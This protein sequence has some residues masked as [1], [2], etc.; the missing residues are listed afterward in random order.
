MKNYMRKMV[1]AICLLVAMAA[2]AE[3]QNSFA[4]QAVIRTAKGELVSNQEVGMRISLIYNDQTIYSETHTPK[5]NQYGNVQVKVGEGTVE[6]GSFAAVPWSTMQVMMKIEADPNGGT[7]Y[8]DLGSIQLQ[9]A[10]YAMYAPTAGAV[11]TVQAGDPKSDSAALF[12][13]KDKDGNVV[14]AVYP[15]GVRVFV[16]D[17]DS[18]KAARTGFAVQGRRAAKDGEEANYFEV[19][20]DGTQV[21][22]EETDTAA[23][24][25]A[26]T[27]FAVSGRR[28]A[29]DV[30][31]DLFTVGSTGTQ[32]Y[33]DEDAAKATRTGFAVQGRRAAKDGDSD[34]YLEI[35]PDGTRVYI[36]NE[37][38]STKAVR[39]GF[40]VQGRRAAKDDADSKIFEINADGTRVYVD[41]EKAVRTGF[42]VQGRRAAKGSTPK[43]FEVNSYGTQI[44]I[45]TEGKPMSTGL[46]VSGRRASKN[47]SQNV[48]YM[49]ID[50]DGT[51][52]YVDYDEA[53]A[54]RTGFA[55]SGR[56]AAKD[57]EQNT[58]LE[59]NNQEG[60][61]AYV[62]VIE[63]KAMPTGFAVSGRKAAKDGEP[64][65]L[66]ITSEKSTLTATNFAMQDKQT[67]NN[68]MSITPETTKLTTD[69]LRLLSHDDSEVLS[70]TSGNVDVK[71]ELVVT[72]EVA[73]TVEVKKIDIHP[74]YL[75]VGEKID[76]VLCADT[77]SVLDASN[78]YVLLKIYG[79]GLFAPSKTVDVEGNSVILF[80]GNGNPT[81]Q[82]DV[83]AAAVIMTKASTPDAK[84][85]IW[86]LKQ[87]NAR[88]IRFG[89]MAAGDTTKQY[90]PVEAFLNS[91][92]P[93]ECLV[94]VKSAV[95]SL[96]TV[97]VVG[98]KV[99]GEKVKLTPQ[100]IEGY[101]FTGWS[102]GRTINPRTVLILHDTAFASAN[103]EINTYNIK[104]IAENGTVEIS[105]EQNEDG[106]YNHGTDIALTAFAAEHY[107]FMGWTDG[108]TA[109]V[110]KFK[111]VSDTTFE[112]AFA[113]DSFSISTLAEN[114]TVTGAGRYPYGTEI[115][116]VAIADTLAGYHFANWSDGDN[117]NPRKIK[118][119][120]NM[121]LTAQFAI[122]H[123]TI[124]YK[125]DDEV[126]GEIE[127]VAY[128]EP[129]A[130]REE[131][132]KEGYTFSGWSQI[133]ATMPMGNV[134]VTGSF[135]IN[136]HTITYMVDGDVYKKFENIPYAS[137]LSVIDNPE[138]KEGYTFS[139]WSELPVTMPDEDVVVTGSF[140]INEYEIA[141]VDYDGK[142]LQSGNVAYGQ[143]PVYETDEPAHA[144][145]AQYTF[146][147]NGW[148][149]ETKPVNG[150]LTYTA[151]YD[152]TVN[153]YAV[154][155]VAENGSVK[156]TTANGNEIEN[157]KK[158]D[159]NTEVTLTATSSVSGYYFIRWSD[160]VTDNPR[161]FNIVKDTAFTAVYK[162]DFIAD[163]LKYI[164]TSASTVSVGKID[165]DNKPTGELTI[166]ATVKD[167]DG[168]QYYVTKVKSYAFD[169]CKDL[170]EVIISE[171][172]MRIDYNAFYDCSSLTSVTIPNSVTS[173]GQEAFYNCS[174]L[175]SVTIPNT[176][177]NIG[178]NAFYNCSMTSVTIPTSV[179][180]IGGDE[181]QFVGGGPFA[182]CDKLE[183]INVDAENA[184]YISLDGVLYSKD[185]TLLVQY[186][187]G[188]QDTLY[189]VH[190]SVKTI[191]FMAFNACKNLKYVAIP[192][193]VK[194]LARY[195]FHFCGHSQKVT[196]P[197]SCTDVKTAAYSKAN[198]PTVY[199]RVSEE[200]APKVV[201]DGNAVFNCK[202]IKLV[203]A[204][205][206]L[207]TATFATP[208]GMGA[209][210]ST[211]F[212]AGTEIELIAN[213]VLGYELES[214]K[215]GE[216][217]IEPTTDGLYK[218]TVTTD[219]TITATW[220]QKHTVTFY[221][222]KEGGSTPVNQLFGSVTP[223]KLPTASSLSFSA[224]EG[225]N[226]AGW[227]TS[228]DGVPVYTD[229]QEITLDNDISL[230]AVWAK[231]TGI[232]CPQQP[233]EQG[234]TLMLKSG[235]TRYGVGEL[236][237]SS[238][239]WNMTLEQGETPVKTFS[240]LKIP[241]DTE[242]TNGA[243]YMLHAVMAYGQITETADFML[244]GGHPEAP[245]GFVYVSGATVSG[246]VSGSSVFIEGRTLDIQYMFVSDH[247]VT[248]AEFEAVMGTNPS[249]FSSATADGE[250]QANRPVEYVN[251][252]AAIAYCNKKSL[253]DGLTPCYTVSAVTDWANL[254][255]SSIPTSSNGT[256][257]AATC[258]FNANGYRL[259]TEAEWEFLARGGN[260][261][262]EGQTDYSGSN[263]IDNV[264]WYSG[265]SDSKTHEVNKKT[266]NSLGI[267]DMSGNV[268]EWCWD[269]TE[270][271]NGGN[272]ITAITAET[273]YTGVSSGSRH[274][275]RGGSFTKE[276]SSHTVG[277]HFD[278]N[279]PY[280]RYKDIGFRVVRNAFSGKSV[281][282]FIKQDGDD[283]NSGLTLDNAMKTFGATCLKMTDANTDYTILVS[284]TLEGPQKIDKFYN[285]SYDI[286]AR[287]LTICGAKGLDNNG[288]P[289]DVIDAKC[290][291]ENKGSALTIRSA[292][293]PI[294]IKNL[295]ITGGYAS[296]GG[297]I[298]VSLYSGDF[299]TLTIGEG[300]VI[301][302]N[303]AIYTTDE[304]GMG[305]G[306]YVGRCDASLD[307]KGGIISENE[308]KFGGGVYFAYGNNFT[309][310]GGT[311][312]GNKA[313]K[314]ADN[315]GG[316]AGGVYVL[317]TL[318][319]SGGQIVGNT[320]VEGGA[321]LISDGCHLAISGSAKIPYGGG[322]GKNDVHTY[323]NAGKPT[324]MA[325]T[326]D[327]ELKGT[328]NVA[329]ITADGWQRGMIVLKPGSNLPDGITEE[330]A[331]RFAL[332]DSDF[333][334][335]IA[336]SEQ[337]LNNSNV[338]IIDAPIYVASANATT[339]KK[340]SAPGSDDANGTLSKPYA[341]LSQ[342]VNQLREPFDYTVL[343][344]G[345][346]TGDDAQFAINED[347]YKANK[348]LLKG[349][350]ADNT[351]DKLN[352]NLSS[353]ITDGSVIS[354]GSKAAGFGQI[355]IRDLTITGGKTT[356]NGGG[357]NMARN[358][359]VTLA[360]GA[361]VSGNTATNGGGIYSQGTL[362]LES[363]SV[364][365]SANATTHATNSSY[366]NYATCGGGIDFA[367]G[368]VTINEGA[369]VA[370]NFAY[371]GGGV[372]Y[373]NEQ[374]TPDDVLTISGGEIA[375]NGC[376]PKLYKNKDYEWSSYGGGVFA[377]GCT[378]NFSSGD[379]HHNFGCDGGGGLFLQK[380]TES[381]VISGGN[382]YDNTMHAEGYNEGTD[383][384]LFDACTL[385]MSGGNVYSS[386][387]NAKSVY[388]RNTSTNL[389]V[390]GDVQFSANT[391]IYLT[392]GTKVTIVGPLSNNNV[393]TITPSSYVS[394]QIQIIQI[395]ENV[396]S[397]KYA[398]EYYKFAVTP[399]SDNSWFVQDN[400][401]FT[402]WQLYI[403]E[404]NDAEHPCVLS[405][406]D[407]FKI[408]GVKVGF[409][410]VYVGSVN[411]VTSDRDYYITMRGYHRMAPTNNGSFLLHNTN[412]NTTFTFHITLEGDNTIERTNTNNHSGSF[413]IIG[414]GSGYRDVKLIF[415]ANTSGTL[416]LNGDPDF[417][418]TGDSATVTYEVAD[419]CTFSGT[420]GSNTYSDIT[421]FF[422]N[423]KNNTNGCSFTVSRGAIYGKFSVSDD[424]QVYFS[425][426]NLQYQ[427]STGTWR[428]AE[429]Q[430][431][432]IGDASANNWHDEEERYSTSD[433]IDLFGW[434]TGSNPT[435]CS[436]N[437]NDYKNYSEWGYNAISNGGNKVGL[438]RTLTNEEWNYLKNR[439]G[440]SALAQIT[441]AGTTHNGMV[442]LPDDWSGSSLNTTS[443]EFTANT[444][445]Q[446]DWKAMEAA[447]AVFLPCAGYR[448]YYEV[449]GVE[450]SGNYWLSDISYIYFD[451]YDSNVNHLRNYELSVRLVQ[452]VTTH[453]VT[454]NT[455]GGDDVASQSVPD[456]GCAIENVPTRSGHVCGGWY[457]DEAFTNLYDFA[458][459]VT[460]DITLY[461]KW[462][463][464]GVTETIDG[465]EYAKISITT[466]DE[467]NNL[468][469]EIDR[470]LYT[471]YLYVSIES[472][473]ILENIDYT[474]RNGSFK[475]L[476]DGHGHTIT[477]K[478]L[479]EGKNVF[480]LFDF[481]NC[482]IIQNVKSQLDESLFNETFQTNLV[483]GRDGERYVYFLGLVNANGNG[484]I[485]RNCWN[486]MSAD[487]VA[488]NSMGG[489]CNSN[490]GLIENC[491]N[492]GNITGTIAS[493]ILTNN[494]NGTWVRVGGITGD[495]GGTIR[496]CVNYGVITQNTASNN[497]KLFGPVGA[498]CG[499]QWDSSSKV[500][501]CYWE[502]LC[503]YN[504]HTDDC[505]TT[506]VNGLEPAATN[507]MVYNDARVRKGTATGC[508]YFTEDGTI[509]AG[510]S[511]MCGSNQTLGYGNSLI[512]A[513]NGYV[514][515]D[516]PVLKSWKTVDGKVVLDF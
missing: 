145:T 212:A 77:A 313:E 97:A 53:K 420:I 415:D 273:P 214:F 291:A 168:I 294:T 174:N 445:Q 304:E 321:V 78:G 28:A 3:A 132:Q 258:D 123:Y 438:W 418:I 128:N 180:K 223:Q 493:G 340:C 203:S 310:S 344:D 62:D 377:D 130:L 312:S 495:N 385:S 222:N 393:A 267:Y 369:K 164:L 338:G 293:F 114:G 407:N 172:V 257:D 395:P 122:N 326:V 390:S 175:T 163:G 268:W 41:D 225:F 156:A 399:N 351:N 254:A 244:T 154:S 57:G 187:Q 384:L 491:I 2:T 5:T 26:R 464:V 508:G 30:N 188:K 121:D 458:N 240:G 454:F 477:V 159:Y 440:K 205:N 411:G 19:T 40:A 92:G 147:F 443:T 38:D 279:F 256:W 498:I 262:N 86:P 485:I 193:G 217:V 281:T 160:G 236:P 292:T 210:G 361:V 439:Q 112:A 448:K 136:H 204:N 373:S 400:G 341:S 11:S 120:K 394:D 337:Y 421:E 427:A 48:K 157:G 52:I 422:N 142:V 139:E 33:I 322:I 148:M 150:P 513:L 207:G 99:Y 409:P 379:I 451:S 75:A 179:S 71:T 10:P 463:Q 284:G 102:D 230:Y 478:S 79:N 68:M 143:T 362:V 270:L 353:A 119:Q 506:E 357:I 243:M 370:Y 32:V 278:N 309:M 65:L 350:N 391:P 499:N 191:G 63:G 436:S 91:S 50:A 515:Q 380:N 383:I 398:N 372:H 66:R 45:E 202:A 46:A 72:G 23:G 307:I 318:N 405:Y 138:D 514:G 149:P 170:T 134:T 366:S 507:L 183:S 238:V 447:G 266:A 195:S 510:T 465:K 459:P 509:T 259:P 343:I 335:K 320:A 474:L 512:N 269:K 155:V 177:T 237:A 479:K 286:V 348:V 213:P 387:A 331:S 360:A 135:A 184:N 433:W 481:T 429:H 166:P 290:N 105:G 386:V 95:D 42:A 444:F 352:R 333:S 501:N 276:A 260:I 265:N 35:N 402:S 431:D 468:F 25:A 12:E 182:S 20:A 378:F 94:D 37:E 43:L 516:N 271:N 397:T 252:Y 354:I 4:Y 251:W 461:A 368:T 189:V 382:I 449:E 311:I 27:G 272:T 367:G 494:W 87:A 306:V 470:N 221:D 455:N 211:W 24:K 29:K 90:V 241:S 332:S 430:Y 81:T 82:H 423:A 315:Y 220:K 34:K 330:I 80:D 144:A 176:V 475:G 289:Q 388:V 452:S 426:G 476:I 419:G 364:V 146:K 201:Q 7:N 216:T 60:T 104:A 15:D 118:V 108:D 442:L 453:K 410:E 504:A 428:F 152:T 76:T 255:Y 49:V 151:V 329:T 503:V 206:E 173:I 300:A 334:I 496:N 17:S 462:K 319:M 432:Y 355:E 460:S 137:E 249:H 192:N 264:A 233:L 171:G 31:A 275:I 253:A 115:E 505:R 434:G 342:V 39:T 67:N 488:I 36:D 480:C 247:E 226:F 109:A 282:L 328:D 371:Q 58:I 484:G 414:K 198:G 297:G 229:E 110:R 487:V 263:T 365:G 83:A 224:P 93:V 56:K 401:T 88:P 103:F 417:K 208:G 376:D 245:A 140:I 283:N 404:E 200:Q 117:T 219:A 277:L 327:G 44:Y 127:D 113:I 100:P 13:V 316:Y 359:S 124:A 349:A 457:T 346:I 250:V 16:N 374:Y 178:Q 162:K 469:S 285:G 84:L 165:D 500:E 186:P 296:N 389:S 336:N 1:S 303:T 347:Y 446:S 489:I 450:S 403:R 466:A 232:I 456:G 98:P 209:D 181:S 228:A 242:I 435:Q 167:G 345:E 425:K 85:I 375:Y 125:L 483:Y 153:Q 482:G 492:T 288:Q 511:D 234:G 106:T 141:F 437:A 129:I 69:E 227:A 408:S 392:S 323:Y 9:P 441:I 235:V 317:G 412:A 218:Y 14:F 161:T 471:D 21:F 18:T 51:R 231:S 169:E 305:G 299:T 406:D 248:Q 239:T 185:T 89:L 158:V 199:C 339:R 64:D 416:N 101:H 55:V 61:R 363:G 96:G 246:A 194:T 381:A 280:A 314:D 197:E 215:V 497:V 308:A 116:L 47:G 301:T 8:I 22:V 490:S 133:P 502:N 54:M 325:I 358:A 59:V 261:T 190:D 467:Y 356:R 6:K 74:V 131:P 111:I 396:T 107:H 196:L 486:D 413:E 73:Q 473:L 324:L 274:I 70:T 302:R 295:K 424:K 126:Y 287:S 298:N 472:D